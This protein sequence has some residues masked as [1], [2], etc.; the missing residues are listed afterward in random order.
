[1]TI[2]NFILGVILLVSGRKLYWFFTAV[3]GMLGGIYLSGVVLD[4]PSQGWQIAFAVIGA[5]LGAILAVA[6]Q[7]LAIALAGFLAGGYGAIFLWQALGLA[8]GKIEWVPFIIGG[9]LGTVLVAIA[10][11]YGLIALSAWAG[12]TL[13]SQ[14]L[15]IGGWVGVAAFIGLLIA[16]VIIQA[17]GLVA[18]RRKKQPAARPKEQEAK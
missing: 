14:Q 17:V 16:G 6:L 15:D 4:A 8:D 7:K 3:A 10:F 5:I 18:E 11:E 1:M 13:I 9:I 12:A 2:L